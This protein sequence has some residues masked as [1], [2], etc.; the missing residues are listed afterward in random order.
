MGYRM[1]AV[2]GAVEIIQAGADKS[3]GRTQEA[4]K[5]GHEERDWRGL[6]GGMDKLLVALAASKG[7]ES[8]M[9]DSF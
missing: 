3:C 6:G 8:E 5:E 9:T 1:E 2:R 4:V 7:K